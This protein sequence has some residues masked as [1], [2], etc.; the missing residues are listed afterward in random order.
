MV[1]CSLP[2][3]LRWEALA[4]AEGEAEPGSLGAAERLRRRY[5]AEV[6]AAA[7]DQVV[8]RRRGRA[9]F[10]AAAATM[11]F[12][13]DG[14][15]QASRPAVARH[16]AAR[17]RASGVRRV[18]D[19]GCGIGADALAF[20]AAGLEVL[21]VERDPHTAEIARANLH[22]RGEV[23]TGDAELLAPELMT[24]ADGVF[25][26]PARRTGSGRLW[27]TADFSPSWSLVTGLLD[28]GR[29]VG[30]KLGPALPHREI[31]ATAEAEW[32]TDH[33]ETVE[34]ALWAG[35]G[36]QPGELAALIMPDHRIAA[37]ATTLPVRRPGRYLY[38]P[39]GAVIRAGAIGVVGR[40]LSAGLL[41]PQIAY[42]SADELIMTP[43][44]TAFE[45]VEELPYAEKVLR[46][47]AR[48]HGVGRLEIK[49]RGIDIDPAQL[50]RRLKPTGPEQATM[51]ITRTPAGARVLIARRLV[52]ENAR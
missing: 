19:L 28:S 46:R 16:H 44:A 42:L 49:K 30:V 5:G 13:R 7:L 48:D 25:V 33:G 26:D 22:G 47:W 4:D 24:A 32:L 36:A 1:S 51:I 50:R 27:R 11:F 34:V 3:P 21:G 20:A 15:E 18:L 31:P 38:E 45:V 39:V 35:P 2:A 52:N 37:A 41:D 14:L 8:L 43:Y 23:I 10:G 40:R 6:A 17:F 29:P 12:T 9:K